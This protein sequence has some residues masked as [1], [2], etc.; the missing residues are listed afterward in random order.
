LN[1]RHRSWWD[2]LVD[3]ITSADYN[4]LHVLAASGTAGVVCFVLARAT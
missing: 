2:V 4:F 1:R 3:A